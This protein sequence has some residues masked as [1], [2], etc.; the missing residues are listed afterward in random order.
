MG[1][2]FGFVSA[3]VSALASGPATTAVVTVTGGTHP[4]KYSLEAAAPCEIESHSAP[5]PRHS[6]SIMLGAPGGNGST[7]ED[8]KVMTV[9]ALLV[10]DADH[11]GGNGQF[12]SE[13]SFGDPPS[14]GTHYAVETRPGEKNQSGSGTV[15]IGQHGAQASVDFDVK[16]ADGVQFKGVIQ[17]SRL[18]RD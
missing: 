13:M 11:A 5:K 14:H 15:T 18:L 10:P 4:G 12:R 8:P 9:M 16:T 3:F 2:L 7:I 17:C 1:F 6:F